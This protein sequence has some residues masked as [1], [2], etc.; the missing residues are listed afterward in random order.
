MYSWAKELDGIA[1]SLEHRY[2]GESAPFGATNPLT[3]HE[4]FSYL[5]LDNIMGDA[6]YFVNILKKNITG[7]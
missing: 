5:T 7:A 2:F 3:Q 1:V 4:E 6:A